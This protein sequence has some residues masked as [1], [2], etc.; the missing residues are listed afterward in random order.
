MDQKDKNELLSQ[1][2]CFIGSL[3]VT[4]YNPVLPWLVIT[5]G[6]E[7]LAQKAE[8]YWLLDEIAVLLTQVPRDESFT[9]IHFNDT[10]KLTVEDGNG[11]PYAAH[12]FDWTTFPFEEFTFFAG[13]NEFGGWT[14]TLTSE[15]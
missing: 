14:L 6:V 4:R 11:L 5:E 3:T 9:S 10:T 12:V 7:F 2:D 15:Y 1:L 13:R 8:C